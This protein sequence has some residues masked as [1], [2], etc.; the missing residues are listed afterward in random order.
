MAGESA[1]SGSTEWQTDRLTSATGKT[2]KTGPVRRLAVAGGATP[3][4]VTTGGASRF[5]WRLVVADY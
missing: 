1:T 5:Q 4:P 2:G 3:L